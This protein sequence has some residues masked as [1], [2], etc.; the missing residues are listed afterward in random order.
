M[1]GSWPLLAASSASAADRR[2]LPSKAPSNSLLGEGFS[3]TAYAEE[4]QDCMRLLYEEIIRALR[5]NFVGTISRNS[6][7]SP[8]QGYNATTTQTWVAILVPK[9]KR[10]TLEL[11]NRKS[12]LNPETPLDPHN[13]KLKP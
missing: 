6:E 8:M 5:K 12:I 11:Y 3:K 2:A 1:G 13:P 4:A 7:M 9:A 10:Y